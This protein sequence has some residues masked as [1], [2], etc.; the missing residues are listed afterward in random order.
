MPQRRSQRARSSRRYEDSSLDADEHN[1]ETRCICGHAELQLPKKSDPDKEIDTGLFIQCDSCQVWQHGFC[2][3]FTSEKDVPEVYYCEKC[4]PELHQVVL[5]P[6]GKTSSYIPH[7]KKL[8][9]YP[10]EKVYKASS[11]EEEEEEEPQ[12][13]KRIKREPSAKKKEKNGSTTPNYREQRRRT[14]NSS[15]QLDYEE[16]LRRVLEESVQDASTIGH[17]G[18]LSEQSNAENDG[19]ERERARAESVADDSGHASNSNTHE[20]DSNSSRK[21][22]S[23]S[24][25]SRWSAKEGSHG[26][27]SIDQ[28]DDINSSSANQTANG[29]S[30]V[31]K[32]PKR[33]P[34]AKAKKQENKSTDSSSAKT[35]SHNFSSKSK[36][37][38][39]QPRS[40]IPEMQKRVAAILEFI[41]RTQVD[42]AE[43]QDERQALLRL[44]KTSQNGSQTQA[45]NSKEKDQVELLFDSSSSLKS[46]DQLTKK[47][48]IWE[49]S[50]GRY[51]DSNQVEEDDYK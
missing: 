3:G 1:D 11:E 37:R 7:L 5:R 21:R 4:R 45:Q 9:K 48:L 15:R 18:E 23:R 42:M 13:E 40:T 22:K 33:K 29:N 39:P 2:V 28:E 47:L 14:Q 49:Q 19:T 20:S 35:T 30:V 31:R 36:P 24:N 8:G 38:I 32:R 44:R 16:T 43:E 17:E 10:P 26:E 12:E 27:E 50:Y 51:R 41:G 6:S 46:L 34:V 25:T